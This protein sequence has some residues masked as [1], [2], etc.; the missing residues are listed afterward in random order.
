MSYSN[1][2]TRGLH[3]TMGSRHKLS[4]Q[5]S[6]SQ[7]QKKNVTD[8]LIEMITNIKTNDKTTSSTL[9]QKKITCNLRLAHLM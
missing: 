9:R 5:K 3:R 1:V 2:K 6:Q 4:K 7:R 8:R